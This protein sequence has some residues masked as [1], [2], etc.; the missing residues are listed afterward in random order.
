MAEERPFVERRF[1]RLLLGLLALYLALQTV[2]VLRKPLVMDEFQGMRTLHRLRQERAFR[3]FQPYKTIGGYLLQLPALLIVEQLWSEADD[4]VWPG[5]LAVKLWTALLLAAGLG[6]AAVR[7][8]RQL[9][10]GRALLALALLLS[11][12]TWLE[13][14]GDLR[15][16]ALTGLVALFGLLSLLEGRLLAATLWTAAAFMVSQKGALHVAALAAALLT[17]PTGSWRPLLRCAAAALALLAAYLGAL[18]LAGADPQRVLAATFGRYLAGALDA[19]IYPEARGFWWQVLSRNPGFHALALVA[20]IR[21][22]RWPPQTAGRALPAPAAARALAAY[23][24]AL[25]GA[26]ALYPQPWPYG[27]VIWLPTLAVVIAWGVGPWGRRAW[28]WALLAVALIPAAL[29]P[30]RV[31]SRDNSYQREVVRLAA[32]ALDERGPHCYLAGLEL[33]WNHRQHGRLGWLDRPTLLRLRD[34]PDLVEAAF[35]ELDD[36]P[37][38]VAISGPRLRSLGPPFPEYL[39]DHYAHVW[40]SLMLYAPRS[41]GPWVKVHHAARYR[42]LEATPGARL[43]GAPVRGGQVIEVAAGRHAVAGRLRLVLELPALRAALPERHVGERP[44]FD[45]VYDW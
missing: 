27:F 39:A 6:W 5:L 37:P 8:R 14:S 42:V 34:N 22:W 35:R 4:R 30:L 2:Y 23:A 24:L 38:I 15:V 19:G 13:R 36:S 44:L 32:I 31:L 1:G 10:A 11:H 21:L 9:G 12:S 18:V 33:V 20:W 3:D 28:C 41:F 43:A 16:D 45:R 7:L 17:R 25:S 40:G 29:R 26:Y